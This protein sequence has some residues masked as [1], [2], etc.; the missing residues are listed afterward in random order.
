MKKLVSLL[1]LLV[2]Q[3]AMADATLR[4]P[5]PDN[6]PGA[7]CPARQDGSAV[8][9]KSKPADARVP[10]KKNKESPQPAPGAGGEPPGALYK[11]PPPAG[12]KAVPQ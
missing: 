9:G 12:P 3:A 1:M 5:K 6:C 7:T 8:D 11:N 4:K 10:P 2:A